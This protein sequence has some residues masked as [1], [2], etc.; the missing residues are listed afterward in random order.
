[1]P[2]VLLVSCPLVEMGCCSW[3][4]HIPQLLRSGEVMEL[5]QVA[6]SSNFTSQG[7]TLEK[8]AV[9]NGAKFSSLYPIQMLVVARSCAH[10][11]Q[12]CLIL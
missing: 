9:D 5:L 11:G 12:G 10:P 7:N 3:R 1:M 8:C 6:Q 2:G 4:E